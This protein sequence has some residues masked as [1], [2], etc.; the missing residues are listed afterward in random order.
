M[1][2]EINRSTGFFKG[3][4]SGKEL[5]GKREWSRD[6]KIAF[7]QKAIDVLGWT[8]GNISNARPSKIIAGAEPDK[9]NEF[10]QLI[11]KAI[12]EKKDSSQGI[13]KVLKGEK[14]SAQKPPT[15]KSS[16]DKPSSDK[17]T[18]DK[19]ATKEVKK[20]VSKQEQ[21]EL[22]AAGNSGPLEEPPPVTHH[23]RP[24][25]RPG[26]RRKHRSDHNE[27]DVNKELPVK[28]E[29]DGLS[30]DGSGGG[31]QVH[32]IERPSTAKGQRKKSIDNGHQQQ[33]DHVIPKDRSPSP[34]QA[35]AQTELIPLTT[36]P[37]SARPPAPRVLKKVAR[38]EEIASQR[39]DSGQDRKPPN[40]ILD[41]QKHGDDNEED[42]YEALPIAKDIPAINDQLTAKP[43]GALT[44]TLMAVKEKYKGEQDDDVSSQSVMITEAQRKK[45]R[46]LVQKEVSILQASIQSLCQTANPL[47]KIMDYVQ[48]ILTDTICVNMWHLYR[49]MLIAWNKN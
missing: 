42:E 40:V 43:E 33:A 34:V 8:T 26:T 47:G 49:K 32:L 13:E 6:D 22:L 10:L 25:H 35:G 28:K 4:Y 31:S 1:L 15:D 12:S 37:S 30:S 38:N 5:D 11:A 20:E 41:H 45:E 24:Q 44:K 18:S 23:E 3:L 48:V 7:F 2:M 17:T 27:S 29:S 36:R 21:P 14:P 46:E 16:T 9:T 19:K 39:V